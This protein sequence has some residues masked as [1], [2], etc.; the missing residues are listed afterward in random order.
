LASHDGKRAKFLELQLLRALRKVA[1]VPLRQQ[2]FERL[3]AVIADAEE[4]RNVDQLALVLK[5]PR[6]K[7]C[8]DTR[9]DKTK[10]GANGKHAAKAQRRG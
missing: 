4:L 3:R 2:T 1:D 7:P 5:F 9:A 6:T 10:S 8:N